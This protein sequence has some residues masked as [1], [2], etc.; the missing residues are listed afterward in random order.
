[1]SKTPCQSTTE[2]ATTSIAKQKGYFCVCGNIFFSRKTTNQ[3]LLYTAHHKAKAVGNNRTTQHKYYIQH[4]YS[5]FIFYSEED[6]Q[7][8]KSRYK[9]EISHPD[10]KL[11][12]GHHLR[13]HTPVLCFLAA[14]FANCGQS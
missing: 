11:L 2:D 1:M 8:T 6:Q 14:A 4:A 12:I 9:N 5:I 7:Q 13:D 10:N 3:T